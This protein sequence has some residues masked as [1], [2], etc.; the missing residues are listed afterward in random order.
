MVFVLPENMREIPGWI[1]P[2]MELICSFDNSTTTGPSSS[3]PASAE[4]EEALLKFFESIGLSIP[5]PV[6]NIAAYIPTL[7][8][9]HE[10]LH[11]A[12]RSEAA[13]R[14]KA[15]RALAE[16]RARHARILQ[17]IQIECREPFVVPA[18]LDAFVAVS[19][20]VDDVS[21]PQA[22]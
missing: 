19:Q 8:K 11:K 18:L 20:I 12:V 10:V 5:T 7:S 2:E 6:E 15:E 22:D 1:N 21:D 14:V 13:A 4:L 16:E 17:D 9:Y 3:H